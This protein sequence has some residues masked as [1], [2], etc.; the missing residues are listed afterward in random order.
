MQGIGYRHPVWSH[1]LAHGELEVAREALDLRDPSPAEPHRWHRQLLSRV[2]C[3]HEDGRTET[4][5]GLFEHL[6]IGPS[7]PHGLT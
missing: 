2:T 3:T 7:R 4:G 5:T 1:G 6:M